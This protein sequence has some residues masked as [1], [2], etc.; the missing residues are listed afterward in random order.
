MKLKDAYSILEIPEGSDKETAKKAFRKLGAKLHPDNKETGNEEKF[1]QLNAAYQ[2]I[3]SGKHSDDPED[4]HAQS[5]GSGFGGV[6]I[7]I[8]DIINGG[9]PGSKRKSSRY[10]NDIFLPQ[11]VSFRESVLGCLKDIRV[12]RNGKCLACDGEGQKTLNNGCTKCGGM[13]TIT[14]RKGNTIYQQQCTACHGRKMLEDCDRCGSTGTVEEDIVFSVHL[15]AGIRDGNSLSI[16][17]RGHY[18]GS[19]FG[20]D[21]YTKVVLNVKVIPQG[22]LKLVDNDVVSEVNV[23]LLEALTGCVKK[24]DTID[25]EKDVIIP[26]G[27]RNNGEVVLHNLGVE[28]KGNQR[29]IVNVAY[30]AKTEKLIDFLK[31][32]LNGIHD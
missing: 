13:G 5:W 31:G 20:T 3:E 11:S 21:Q 2:L 29:V 17:S 19:G 23:S 15:P 25:G 12:H 16:G 26:E 22:G 27:T 8:W 4:Q 1:K 18:V 7:N 24:T 10:A 14:S 9:M 32:E 28:R 6:P 30:P